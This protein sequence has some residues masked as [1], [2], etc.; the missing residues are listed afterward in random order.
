MSED[1]VEAVRRLIEAINADELPRDLIDPD[2][3]LK[4]ATTAVTDAT[5]HGHEGALQWRRDMF[6]VVDG[7][8]LELR[9]VLSSGPDHVAIANSLVGHGSSS[10][11]PV[12]LRWVSV[13]W[14]RDG[15]IYKTAGYNTRREAFEAIEQATERQ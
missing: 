15:R 13:F 4:N 1:N 3:E 9:E 12:E 2:L 14:F 7:A 8:R 11:V 5:Y 10:G 6:D